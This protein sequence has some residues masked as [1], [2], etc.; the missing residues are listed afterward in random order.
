MEQVGALH[1]TRL[2][3]LNDSKVLFSR[4]CVCQATSTNKTTK[5]YLMPVFS[6]F[7]FWDP[8]T[9]FCF[10]FSFPTYSAIN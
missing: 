9:D 4:T 6:H 2:R 3:Q 7:T 5:V 8:S 1:P 10:F